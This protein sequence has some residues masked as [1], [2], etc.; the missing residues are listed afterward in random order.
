MKKLKFSLLAGLLLVLCTFS[1]CSQK[2]LVRSEFEASTGE[3]PKTE[4]SLVL[5]ITYE[6][7][8]PGEAF[9]L[10]PLVRPIQQYTPEY[11][12]STSDPEIAEVDET[13]LV[14]AKGLGR[15]VLEDCRNGSLLFLHGGCGGA[16]CSC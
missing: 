8:I 15:C 11:R 4:P 13:G 12:F 3:S 5:N 14:T 9:R 10:I 1:A 7:L 2:V 16:A 6:E